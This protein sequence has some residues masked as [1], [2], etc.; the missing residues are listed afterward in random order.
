MYYLPRQGASPTRYFLR[1]LVCP[2]ALMSTEDAL[3]D[4]Q[5]LRCNLEQFVIA[6]VLNGLIKAHLTGWGEALINFLE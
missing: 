3:A 1:A 4:P 6:Q 5:A 2:A